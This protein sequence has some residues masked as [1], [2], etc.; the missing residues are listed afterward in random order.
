MCEVEEMCGGQTHNSDVALVFV[1]ILLG[2]SFLLHVILHSCIID[3]PLIVLCGAHRAKSLKLHY[4]IL[5]YSTH[6]VKTPLK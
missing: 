6:C 2:L 1:L 4:I 3:M 5:F